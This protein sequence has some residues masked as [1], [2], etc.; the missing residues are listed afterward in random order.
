MPQNSLIPEGTNTHT[1]THTYIAKKLN[2]IV[3]LNGLGILIIFTEEKF[4]I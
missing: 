1:H 4:K 2:K 3:F